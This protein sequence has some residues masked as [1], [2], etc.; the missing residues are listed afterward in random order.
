MFGS[1]NS[2]L[3][4]MRLSHRAITEGHWYGCTFGSAVQSGD[5]SCS[6]HAENTWIRAKPSYGSK[7]TMLLGIRRVIVPP[8]CGVPSMFHQF[9]VAVVVL[10]VVAVG[11][12]LVVG[13]S[14]VV[15]VVLV[16]VVVVVAVVELVLQDASR[17]AA[18][19]KQLKDNQITFFFTFYLHFD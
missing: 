4:A 15:F 9:R 19:N 11:G 12:V 1:V 7:L 18:T 2:Q 13:G 17:V 10:V 16:V 5:H 3:A 6:I 14:V 8:Y